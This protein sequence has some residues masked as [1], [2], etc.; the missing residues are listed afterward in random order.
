MRKD[1]VIFLTVTVLL[2]LGGANYYNLFNA[3]TYF[4][5]VGGI[6]GTHFS[7]PNGSMMVLSLGA[8]ALVISWPF[9]QSIMAK[10]EQYKKITKKPQSNRRQA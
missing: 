10:F 1:G 9:R 4:I 5:L 2:L 3:F 6:P 7:L 8:L